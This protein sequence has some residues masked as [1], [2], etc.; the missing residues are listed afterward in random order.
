M[1]S[2]LF[3]FFFKQPLV[4]TKVLTSSED[5]Y[6]NETIF[7]VSNA[8]MRF[9]KPRLNCLLQ[10]TKEGKGKQQEEKVDTSELQKE[11]IEKLQAAIVRIM[12]ARREI[13]HSKLIE[14]TQSQM[15]RWF[16]P[17][18]KLI[19]HAIDQLIEKEYIKR[20]PDDSKQYQY[21]A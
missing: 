11:R 8:L 17:E 13:L 1:I 21:I 4:I 2:F 16:T 3:H 6:T 9:A 5:N 7:T 20:H 14:E 15:S 10:V 19:K 12:K 18:V